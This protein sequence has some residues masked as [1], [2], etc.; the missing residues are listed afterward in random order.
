MAKKKT[1]AILAQPGT[2]A[3][4]YTLDVK[5]DPENDYAFEAKAIFNDGTVKSL[6]SG[7]GGGILAVHAEGSPRTLD[8]TWKEISNALQSGVLPIIF[9]YTEIGMTAH[10]FLITK[11]KKISTEPSFVCEAVTFEINGTPINVTTIGTRFKAASEDE[12]PQE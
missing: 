2:P 3:D 4:G 10:P 7:G 8:K 12:Y 6:G 9:T 1:S 11:T 5:Y